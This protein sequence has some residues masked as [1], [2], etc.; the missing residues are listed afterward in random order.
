VAAFA[1][2]RKLERL[3]NVNFDAHFDVRQ[4]GHPG[5]GSSGT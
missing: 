5:R 2:D 4:P 1:G 3:G